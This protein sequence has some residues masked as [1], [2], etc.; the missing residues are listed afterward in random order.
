MKN[1]SFKVIEKWLTENGINYDLTTYGNKFFDDG[2][3]VIAPG[4]L[5]GFSFDD[6]ENKFNKLHDL[7]KFMSRKKKYDVDKYRYGGG[8]AVRIMT[9][10]DAIALNEWSKRRNAAIA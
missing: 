8:I 3:D 6:T 9:A 1:N 5:I 7:E 2:S 4:I 10:E